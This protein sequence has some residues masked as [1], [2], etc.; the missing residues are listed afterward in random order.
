[1][2]GPILEI[3]DFSLSFKNQQIFKGVNYT[4][5]PGIYIFSG[6]SG[7]GKTSLMR[8]IAGL[9][10]DYTGKILLNGKPV[11]GPTPEIFMMHQHYK[12]FPWLNVE[13]NILFLYKGHKRKP[14]EEQRKEVKDII[15][16][17]GLEEHMYKRPAQLSG[18]QNQRVNIATGLISTESKVLLFDEM[19]SA[20]DE[21]NDLNVAKLIKMNQKRTNNISIIITH[22]EHVAQALGGKI[23]DFEEEFYLQ[24]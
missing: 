9:N 22:E 23:I 6:E 20:L 15:N 21:E 4:F 14:T 12:S 1:M 17:I 5:T 10:L 16:L 24:K 11:T 13:D 3:K 18:G 8:C 19:T 7:I 2:T